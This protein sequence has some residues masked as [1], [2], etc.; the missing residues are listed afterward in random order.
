MSKAEGMTLRHPLRNSCPLLLGEGMQSAMP[1]GNR[2]P[3]DS[4]AMRLPAKAGTLMPSN[5]MASLLLLG[6]GLYPC[7]PLSY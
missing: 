1:K 6:P 7:S 2:I 3:S 4:E 5:I